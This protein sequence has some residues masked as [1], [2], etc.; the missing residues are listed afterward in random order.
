MRRIVL[1]SVL[2]LAAGCHPQPKKAADAQLT[3]PVATSSAVTLTKGAFP[4]GWPDFIPPDPAATSVE[5]S[6]SQSSGVPVLSAVLTSPDEPEKVHAFYGQ[7]I[8]ERQFTIVSSS[9]TKG[10]KVSLYRRDAQSFSVSTRRDDA[11][12]VTHIELTLAGK[13]V[14]QVEPPPPPP[15][16]PAAQKDDEDKQEKPKPEPLNPLLP[17]YPG[18]KGGDQPKL[19]GP[20]LNLHMTTDDSLEQVC[21]YYEQFYQG[22]GF[23]AGGRADFGT[24]ISETF[25]GTKGIAALNVRKT[26]G[27]KDGATSINLSF[28]AA[29]Y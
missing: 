11:Q 10:E 12:K 26:A 3:P 23:T 16:K 8:S 6:S 9:E 20:R 21:I 28:E 29:H 24:Q 25:T 19:D 5:G 7:Q 22:Q 18:S 13:Y 17:A 14:E 2:A 1:C 4:A 15:A 27:S